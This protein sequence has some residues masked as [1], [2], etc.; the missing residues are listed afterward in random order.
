MSFTYTEVETYIKKEIS[1]KTYHSHVLVITTFHNVIIV[2]IF[3]PFLL[4]IVV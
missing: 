3:M 2:F 4:P 1:M